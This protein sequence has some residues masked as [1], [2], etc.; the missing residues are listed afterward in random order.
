MTATAAASD[1]TAVATFAGGCF[2]CVE[3][4]FEDLDGVRGAISGYTGG[5]V[6]NPT[7]KQVSQGG[8]G[9]A[10]AVQVEFDPDKISY[11]DLLEVFWH[12]IDPTVRDRQFCDVGR[13]YRSAIFYHDEAQRNA[14]ERSMKDLVAS[15]RFA[16][17]LYTEISPATTF[18]AAEAS[19]QDYAEK[20]PIRY[21][22]Y[23]RGCG[24]DRR[25]EELWGDQQ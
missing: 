10:E 18:Y 5:N 12:N 11:E 6:E 13:Q 16:G 1:R 17:P 2:W 23:R 24:R 22:F 14:A 8:T 7:Y 3:A 20:H 9:H 15:Q 4:E 21:A 19:H 25:L